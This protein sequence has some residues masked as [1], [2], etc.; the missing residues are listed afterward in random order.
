M[1]ER[2]FVDMLDTMNENCRLFV[3]YIVED[4]LSRARLN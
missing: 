3:K 2:E 1:A 4:M